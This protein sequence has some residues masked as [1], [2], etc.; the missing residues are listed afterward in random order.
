VSSPIRSLPLSGAASEGR[1]K[2]KRDLLSV[3]FS[4][5]V[6]RYTFFPNLASLDMNERSF[7][8]NERGLSETSRYRDPPLPSP[9]LCSQKHDVTSTS[10][11]V[12]NPP[13]PTIISITPPLSLPSH[14]TLFNELSLIST[15]TP[16]EKENSVAFS[17]AVR[18]TS[19]IVVSW[20]RTEGGSLELEKEEE[21]EEE[22]RTEGRVMAKMFFPLILTVFRP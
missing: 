2:A 8:R 10:S 19:S 1:V 17:V 9:P 6:F 13:S 12:K 14:F 3:L 22:E 4:D 16:T 21:K 11:T 5:D 15:P 18:L 20:M 7:N